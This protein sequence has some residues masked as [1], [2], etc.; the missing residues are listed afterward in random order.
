LF[1]GNS[2]IFQLYHD[3]N[4]LIFLEMMRSALYYNN[5][6]NWIFLVQANWNNHLRIDMSPYSNTLSRFPANPALSPNAACLS[7]KQQIPILQSLVKCLVN[8]K[9]QDIQIKKR[10]DIHTKYPPV[11]LKESH[12]VYITYISMFDLPCLVLQSLSVNLWTVL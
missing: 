10:H 4:K 11:V 3:E 12:I 1:N 6:L 8:T 9:Y 7:E 5:T 2:A